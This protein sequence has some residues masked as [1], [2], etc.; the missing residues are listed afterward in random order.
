MPCVGRQYKITSR[1][2]FKSL[3]SAWIAPDR[4]RAVTA[5]DVNGFGV[6]MAQRRRRTTGRKLHD[7]LVGFVVAVEITKCTLYA[8]ALAGPQSDFHGFHVF[9]I[10]AADKRRSLALTP[11]LIHVDTDNGRLFLRIQ[12]VVCRAH[13]MTSDRRAEISLTL[14]TRR[15]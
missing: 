12:A 3:L 9:D 5:D 1:S 2:P 4:C 7:L 13:R 15:V 6:E 10:H 11:L 8:I 14:F